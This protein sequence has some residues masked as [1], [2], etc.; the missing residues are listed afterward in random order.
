MFYIS[1][2]KQ[3]F[4]LPETNYI[5]SGSFGYLRFYRIKAFVPRRSRSLGFKL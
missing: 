2:L 3:H 4:R 5:Y 1:M